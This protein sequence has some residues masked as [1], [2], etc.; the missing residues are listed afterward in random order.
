MSPSFSDSRDITPAQYNAQKSYAYDNKYTVRDSNMFRS[1]GM[2]SQGPP[3]I[4]Q[5]GQFTGNSFF[6]P[7]ADVK[8]DGG[9]SLSESLM[10]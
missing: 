3:Q 10:I 9:S 8:N 6:Q 4:M 7:M 5:T 2:S 1:D